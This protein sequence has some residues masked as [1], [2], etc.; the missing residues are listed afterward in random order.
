VEAF[1]IAERITEL[2][3]PR[4]RISPRLVRFLAAIRRSEWLRVGAGVTFLGSSEK[5]ERELGFS[6]RSLETGLR[7]TLRYEMALRANSHQPLGL[8]A[9]TV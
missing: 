3:A 5:A 6:S 9:A 4:Y 2:P 8:R 1:D 7:E